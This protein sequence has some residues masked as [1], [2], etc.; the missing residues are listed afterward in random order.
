M[1]I[2]TRHFGEYITRVDVVFDRYVG[3]DSIKAVTR[4]KRVG[5]Q[6]P[7]R[8]L[9]EGFI[10][11]DENK[12]DL[13]RFLSDVIMTKGKDLPD[14]YEMVTGGGFI[15]A[16]DARSTRRNET[17]LSGNHEEA[18]TRLILHAC[19]AAD[20]GYERVLVICRDTDVLLLLVHF[21]PVVEVW[22]IAGTAKK[23]KCYPVHE[24]SRRLTQ[25]VRDNLLSFHA[26][27]GCDTTSAFSGHG[28]KSCWRT[29]QKHP[30]LVS[31]VGR[32][33]ELAP[34][35]EFVCHLYGTPE[36][37]TTNHARLHLFG[38]AKKVLEML[39][40][41]R[42]ALELHAIRA[43]YQAKIWLQANKELI[44][45]PSPVSTTAWK[46][47]A[48]SLTAVW[49]RLPAIP[50]AC[51]E[52]VTCGCKSKCKT[53]RCSCFKKNMQCTAACGCDVV[54]CCNPAGQ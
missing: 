38:K 6:K 44:D 42:D 14:R 15:N 52:L 29:F 19:E 10:A 1:Q 12:A 8:K 41:T 33:G 48:T 49:T 37:P 2:A 34:V 54:G 4:S 18:D 25:P 35:E 32:D 11:L 28:K 40:P 16:T 5:K 43:N 45:V 26:L 47:D 51:V 21:M 36:Q 3:K 13:A 7:I 24:V 39:P 20:E 50:D 9:I 23:R 46:K 53:A 17:K 31:G 30:L 22:M 27:T